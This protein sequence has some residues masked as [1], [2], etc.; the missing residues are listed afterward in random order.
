MGSGMIENN[1]II[2]GCV[3]TLGFTLVSFA[4]ELDEESCGELGDSVM[5]FQSILEDAPQAAPAHPIHKSKLNDGLSTPLTPVSE[6]PTPETRESRQPQDEVRNEMLFRTVIYR[7]APPALEPI[8]RA[9]TTPDTKRAS[10]G[11][12][13]KSTA[14]LNADLDEFFRMEQEKK[15]AAQTPQPARKAETVPAQYPSES[16]EDHRD[17]AARELAR[18]KHEVFLLYAVG[19]GESTDHEDAEDSTIDSPPLL[20]QNEENK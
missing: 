13:D 1:I 9:V 8:Q 15:A 20:Q 16:S 12:S 19:T 6:A 10:L 17:P 5:L 4:M 3:L 11:L 14:K 7:D 2:K 18:Q